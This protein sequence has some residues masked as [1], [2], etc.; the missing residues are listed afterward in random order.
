MNQKYCIEGWKLVKN[1]NIKKALELAKFCV[2]FQGYLEKT[3]G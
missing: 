1:L 3:E 2:D